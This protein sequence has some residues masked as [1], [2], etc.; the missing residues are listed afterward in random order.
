MAHDPA[1]VAET[2]DWFQKAHDD[3]EAA[4]RLLS[5]IP[6]LA[7]PAAFHTQ[8]AAEKAMKAFL[9]WN[10]QVFRK[11]HSL[12]EIGEACAKLDPGLVEISSRVAPISGWAVETRYPGEWSSPTN[13]EVTQALENVRELFR[14]ILSRLPNDVGL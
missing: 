13:A 12:I 2:R 4:Q 7:A 6:P 8:Q 5:G 10:G 1:L 9:T 11:I 3:L 14:A